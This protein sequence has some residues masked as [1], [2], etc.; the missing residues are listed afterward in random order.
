MQSYIQSRTKD[1]EVLE[2]VLKNYSQIEYGLSVD[3]KI[4]K[5]AENPKRIQ[6]EAQKQGFSPSSKQNLNRR[7]YSNE[8]LKSN[9]SMT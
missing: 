4:R 6:R 2:F 5:K 1:Y 9:A 3:V 7:C 8:K